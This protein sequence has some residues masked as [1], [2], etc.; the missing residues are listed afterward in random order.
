MF[1]LLISRTLQYC[2]G[3]LFCSSGYF[4]AFHKIQATDTENFAQ[5]SDSISLQVRQTRTVNTSP[6][7]WWYW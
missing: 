5:I 3:F 7:P 4:T 1:I 2:E 6:D